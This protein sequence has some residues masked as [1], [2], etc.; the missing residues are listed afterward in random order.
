MYSFAIASKSGTANLN[1]PPD[2]NFSFHLL[3][4]QLFLPYQ[5]IQ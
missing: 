3:K 5:N 1:V 2:F 4:I